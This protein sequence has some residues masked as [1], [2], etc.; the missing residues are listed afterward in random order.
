LEIKKI[1]VRFKNNGQYK[2]VVINQA[3]SPG[4]LAMIER[5]TV[6][7]G[8]CLLLTG[9]QFRQK[10]HMLTM[11]YGPPYDR[12]CLL[13]RTFSWVRFMGWASL[14]TLLLKGKPFIFVVSNPPLMPLIIWFFSCFRKFP[15]A[16]LVWDI[17]PDHLV[18]EG[19]I[20]PRGL[21]HQIWSNLNACAMHDADV[22][23]TLGSKMVEKL[24]SGLY[25][26]KA[27]YRTVVVPNWADTVGLKP[28]P[29]NDNSFAK[30]HNQEKKL[31]VLYSGNMGLTHSIETIGE[32]ANL[33]RDNRYISFLLIGD[34]LGRRLVE[35]AIARYKLTNVTLLPRQRW[36][37][38]PFSLASGD[39]ALVIQTKGT[40]ALSVPSKIYSSLAVGSAIIALADE[41]SDLAYLVKKHFAGVICHQ[42]DPVALAKIIQELSQR[43][44]YLATLRKN[45]RIAAV[46]FFSEEAVFN[47]FRKILKI[48]FSEG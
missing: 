27:P 3:H 45:A 30:E 46:N 48:A 6:D 24:N 21:V 11:R 4:F 8:P 28:I 33:L 14:K 12:R 31:T 13:I 1:K 32:T 34:G 5:L 47:S 10:G 22:V 44:D 26:K 9:M 36:D 2:W 20:K 40:E 15:Y 38:L 17:Y 29:K 42:N 37:K 18:H 19:L 41:E 23:I 35:K 16:M 39:V 25:Q 43:P 7:L